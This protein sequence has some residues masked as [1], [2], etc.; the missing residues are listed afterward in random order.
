M[1]E[2]ELRVYLHSEAKQA[3]YDQI[4]ETKRRAFE[5]EIAYSKEG[6]SIQGRPKRSALIEKKDWTAD[7][8]IQKGG[9]SIRGPSDQEQEGHHCDLNPDAETFGI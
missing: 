5:A 7:R 1:K 2:E 4:L 9:Q 8:E 3:I 6:L